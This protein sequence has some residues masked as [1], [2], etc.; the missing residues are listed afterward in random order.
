MSLSRSK[1]AAVLERRSRASGNSAFDLSA[2][3]FGPQFRFASSKAKFKIARVPRRSGKTHSEAALLLHGAVNPP[4]ANQGFITL[5]LKNAK[6][7]VWPVLKRLNRDYNLGGIPN[8]SEGAMRFPHL[9]NEPN[10]YLGGVKDRSEVDKIRGW[11]GGA[12]RFVVDEAQ[13]IRTSLFEELIDEVIEP[14][15]L[16]HD[17]Q[18][19][20]TGTPG[21]VPAGY[22]YDI[23]VGSKSDGWEHH[24]WTILENPHLERKSGKPTQQMLDELRARRHWDVDNPTYKREYLGQWV[25][26]PDALVFKYNPERNGFK[27]LPEGKW[28]YVIGVDLGF[29]D[30]DAIAVLG[31]REHDKTVY[32]VDEY[33]QRKQGMTA[34]MAQVQSRVD[35]YHPLRIVM[36]LSGGALKSVEDFRPRFALPLESTDKQRKFD[37]IELVNDALRAGLLKS[38]AR[39]PFAEDCMQVQWDLDERALGKLKIAE[40]YHSDITDAVLYAFRACYGW[41]QGPAVEPPKT[42]GD[43]Y[44]L[45]LARLAALQRAEEMD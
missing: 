13:A 43:A 39:G 19:I 40:D 23:D 25:H 42:D 5:S 9:P 15:L 21:P 26:D 20:V 31:W 24:F 45:R 10:I 28:S 29:K 44:A 11:E 1:L 37:Y 7:L 16:D 41:I 8:E 34:L 32:V 30:A 22:F 14:A 18:L 36:D 38:R 4:F 6:K 27:E 35:K 17:G 33:T 2:I 12:K 3:C